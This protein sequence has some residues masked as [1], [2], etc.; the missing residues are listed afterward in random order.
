MQA[1][2][3]SVDMQAGIYSVDMQAG[4]YSVDMQAGIY[5]VDSL[6]FIILYNNDS[7]CIILY[8]IQ[9][10]HVHVSMRDERR[11]EERR[12]QGQTDNKAKQ[13]STPKAV[14]FPK[15]NELPRVGLEHAHNTPNKER[16]VLTCSLSWVRSLVGFNR[17]GILV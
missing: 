5:S 2:I 1:G 17:V 15:K 14:T 6:R 4:I 12:K 13:H 11:N 16:F 7:L 9:Y 8:A 10:I 3:Y